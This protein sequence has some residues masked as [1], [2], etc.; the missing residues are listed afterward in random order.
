MED[1]QNQATRETRAVSTLELYDTRAEV[2]KELSYSNTV[3]GMFDYQ[4]TTAHGSRDH[5]FVV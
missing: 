3:A 5:M 2:S 4:Q 1:R